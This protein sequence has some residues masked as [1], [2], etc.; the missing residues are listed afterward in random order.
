MSDL[1]VQ[2]SDSPETEQIPL[3]VTKVV[4]ML[5]DTLTELEDDL[6]GISGRIPGSLVDR[7]VAIVT[8]RPRATFHLTQL[9][10][11]DTSQQSRSPVLNG[12][13]SIFAHSARSSIATVPQK[14]H[15]LMSL[16]YSTRRPTCD[17]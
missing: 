6:E 11:Q 3:P 12:L 10:T 1:F 16:K 5:S 2:P 15:L 7:V 13:T 9:L 8:C 17:V 4:T 14:Y